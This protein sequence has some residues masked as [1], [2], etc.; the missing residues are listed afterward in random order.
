MDI[1]NQV[2]T[3]REAAG[4]SQEELAKR[5]YVSRQTVSNWERDRTYPD[6]Q[7]LLL[8][9]ELFGTS[10]DTLVKGDVDVMDEIIVRDRE[11][12]RKITLLTYVIAAVL[13]VIACVVIFTPA[14]DALGDVLGL[15]PTAL[16]VLAVT[17]CLMAA[18]VVLGVKEQQILKKHDIATYRQLRAFQHGE[19]FKGN[20]ASGRSILDCLVL[21]NSKQVAVMLAIAGVL[22]FIVGLAF[23]MFGIC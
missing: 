3:R 20:A 15:M 12:R 10:L 8:L 2:R 5:V 16:L 1:G 21:T 11:L 7:S 6:V 23:V 13:T 9:S 14:L 4:L 22:G 17:G 18:L 19:D